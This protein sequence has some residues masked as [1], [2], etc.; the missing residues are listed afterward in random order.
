MA[1]SSGRL[2]TDAWY[3]SISGSC[4]LQCCVSISPDCANPDSARDDASPV[5]HT[6]GARC[7]CASPFAKSALR[8]VHNSRSIGSNRS[9]APLVVVIS[10]RLRTMAIWRTGDNERAVTRDQ[11]RHLLEH[12]C[13]VFRVGAAG[14]VDEAGLP[15]NMPKRHHA[16]DNDCFMARRQRRVSQESIGDGIRALQTPSVAPDY[17]W[18]VRSAASTRQYFAPAP[19]A[20]H[21]WRPGGQRRPS[22]T[23]R[24]PKVRL[25][26]ADAQASRSSSFCNAS[27]LE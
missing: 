19:A 2:D 14:V 21:C 15:R 12:Q 6:S 24:A 16:G 10:G 8:S 23:D 25:P 17:A 22:T 3:Q 1:P 18:T 5:I 27:L 13:R 7:A 26:A 20:E 11:L 9:T 4:F